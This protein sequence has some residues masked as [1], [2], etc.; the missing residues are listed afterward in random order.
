MVFKLTPPSAPEGAWTETVLYDFTDANVDGANPVTPLVL[1]S[2]GVFYGTSAGGAN[3]K[4]VIFAIE[5]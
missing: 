4:G 5:P 3:G 1:S 2:T